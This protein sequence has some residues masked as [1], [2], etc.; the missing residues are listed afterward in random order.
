M[1]SQ[2][3]IIFPRETVKK[4]EKEIQKEPSGRLYCGARYCCRGSVQYLKALC[5]WQCALQIEGTVVNIQIGFFFEDVFRD[6]YSSLIHYILMAVS[7]PSTPLSLPHPPF[8][9]PRSMPSLFPIK[10][11]NKKQNNNSKNQASEEYPLNVAWQD[12]I[13]LGIN[14]H[15]EAR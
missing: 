8:L 2:V 7:S 6:V 11:T 13:R 10:Q 5:E 1:K 12:T 14:L 9:S 3:W 15:T 4:E